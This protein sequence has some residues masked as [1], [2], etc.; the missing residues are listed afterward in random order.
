M[1]DV[2]QPNSNKQDSNKQDSNKQDSNKQDSNK[3]T[4]MLEKLAYNLSIY[5]LYT[6]YYSSY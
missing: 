2:T 1:L 4:D 3:T 5:I 6:K